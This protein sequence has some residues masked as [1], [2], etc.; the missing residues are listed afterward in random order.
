MMSKKYLE[1][2]MLFRRF[3]ARI[4]SPHIGPFCTRQGVDDLSKKL[5]AALCQ[6]RLDHLKAFFKHIFGIYMGHVILKWDKC[7]V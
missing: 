4:R 7:P 3:L 1:Q 2:G 6:L 5:I